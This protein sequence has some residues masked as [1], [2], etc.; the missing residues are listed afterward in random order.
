MPRR[1]SRHF[2]FSICDTEK[3]IDRLTPP[4]E[5]KASLRAEA[6]A[7]RRRVWLASGNSA[8]EAIVTAGL[9]VISTLDSGEVVAGYCPIRDELDPLR[10][11][12]ALHEK[13][14][15]I[16]LPVTKPGPALSFREWSPGSPLQRGKFDLQEPG[17][18]CHEYNP[19]LL[20]VPLLAFDRSGT[21]LGY[22]AGYYNSAL[23]ALRRAGRAIAIG[24][25][26]DEQEFP[27]IPREP[28][29]EPLDM[30]LTPSRII[31]CKD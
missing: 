18:D 16:V 1:P 11:V 27:K 17:E 4:R 7:I 14:C 6:S 25:G 21:R 31:A 3:A 30:I 28:Q 29:D 15:R 22:G 23:R 19:A 2:N 20:L 10:L 12:G 26:F 5:Q 13:G 24:I 9:K 8:R